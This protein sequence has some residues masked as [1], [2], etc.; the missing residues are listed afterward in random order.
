MG[1]SAS[2]VLEI[3]SEISTIS[4]SETAR[5]ARS[6]VRRSICPIDS[7]PRLN[8]TSSTPWAL[9]MDSQVARTASAISGRGMLTSHCSLKVPVCAENLLPVLRN[10]AVTEH[11]SKK[12]VGPGPLRP[13]LTLRATRTGVAPIR[14]YAPLET[15]KPGYSPVQ[16]DTKNEPYVGSIPSYQP[17]HAD[18]AG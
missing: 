2:G 11:A 9:R 4:S 5:S 13:R 7:P 16:E 12:E 8:V 10:I 1:S 6:T 17:R 14:V 15:L 18:L 3:S